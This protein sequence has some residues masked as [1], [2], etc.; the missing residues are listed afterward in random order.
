MTTMTSPMS[1]GSRALRGLVEEEHL[2][3]HA[4]GPGDGRPLLLAAGQARRV[5]VALVDHLDLLE[6][7][8]GGLDGLRCAAR[9]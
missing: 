4:E 5:L 8:L 2:G 3:L 7:P 6:E 1:S 9:P